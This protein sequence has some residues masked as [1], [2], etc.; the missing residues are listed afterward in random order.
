MVREPGG[1][2]V[3][4]DIVRHPGS[5]V[6]LAIDNSRR[7]PR[8]LLER[9]YRHAAGTYLWELPAGHKDP[10]ENELAAAKRELREET[11][12]TAAKWRRILRFYV[13]PGFLDERMTLFLAT[14]LHPGKAQPEADEK[15]A[16]RFFPFRVA[17]RMV[18]SGRIQDA[19]TIAG[20]L[21]LSAAKNPS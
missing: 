15:I 14:G 1:T 17:L 16:L 5:V 11:G 12:F 19:K 8:L 2:L 9:Q 13:S 21:W 3:R 18:M 7:E 4:R 10:D 20:I 6:V